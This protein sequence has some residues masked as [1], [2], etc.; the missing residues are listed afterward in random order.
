MKNRLLSEHMITLK[1][2]KIMQKRICEIQLKNAKK[3]ESIE[4]L[5][6]ALN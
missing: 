4:K 5:N 6:I 3:Q 1:K 2:C